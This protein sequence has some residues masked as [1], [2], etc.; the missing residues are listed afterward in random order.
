MKQWI[1]AVHFWL[2]LTALSATMLAQPADF[3]DAAQRFELFRQYLARRGG[4]ITRNQFAG[5]ETLA[6]WKRK[7]PALHRQLLYPLR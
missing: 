3:H 5:I 6:D 7:R 4:E 2:I 1:T